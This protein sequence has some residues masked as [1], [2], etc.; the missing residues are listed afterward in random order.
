MGGTGVLV[1]VVL[2]LGLIVTGALGV[3]I[4]AMGYRAGLLLVGAGAVALVVAA[5]LGLVAL[6][7][8]Q[9][10][11]AVGLTALIVAVGLSAFFGY[12]AWRSG[13]AP[14]IHDVTTAPGDTP[15]FEAVLPLRP[16][17]SNPVHLDEGAADRQRSAYPWLRPL[18]VSAAP[19]AA[20]AGVVAT[21]E[22]MGW[23]VVAADG[24]EGRLEA[25]AS[26][27]WFGFDDDIV[28]RVRPDGDGARID[29]RS[30][31]REGVSDLGTNARRIRRF[32]DGLAQR[33]DGG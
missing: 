32:L 25:T 16:Q 29:V 14:P 7:R 18:R 27:F 1:V 30:A 19:A 5:G 31:S 24:A 10:P 13:S 23:T 17:G 20:F 12:W 9:S 26:T 6:A 11:G 28:V 4:D 21:A 3:R 22:A 33:L 15:P 8:G 2:G